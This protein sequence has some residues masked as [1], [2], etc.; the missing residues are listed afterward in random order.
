M[1]SIGG[2]Y[3]CVVSMVVPGRWMRRGYGMHSRGIPLGSVRGEGQV[4][5]AL[6]PPHDRSVCLA[7][8]LECTGTPGLS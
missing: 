6:S 1:H 8:G 2:V 4:V 7:C 5:S 3:L